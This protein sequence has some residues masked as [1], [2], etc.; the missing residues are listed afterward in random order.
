M[1]VTFNLPVVPFMLKPA[2][3]PITLTPPTEAVCEIAATPSYPGNTEGLQFVPVHQSEVIPTGQQLPFQHTDPTEGEHATCLSTEQ[4]GG[5]AVTCHSVTKSRKKATSS[6]E[7]PT[8]EAHDV[9]PSE[10]NHPVNSSDD[11]SARKDV[12]TTTQ[13]QNS[14]A[15]DVID[16]TEKAPTGMKQD[17]VVA[18]EDEQNS[19]DND[20]EKAGGGRSNSSAKSNRAASSTAGKT[21]GKKASREGGKVIINVSGTTYFM[22]RKRWRQLHKQWYVLIQC[23]NK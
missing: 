8:K 14:P 20:P 13:C 10:T 17:S 16:R 21:A 6:S 22:S 9:T 18:K 15:E 3:V 12:I 2:A 4:P 7:N 5:M 23:L 11:E 19:S 1:P